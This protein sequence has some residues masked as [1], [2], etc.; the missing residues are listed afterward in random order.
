[1]QK[2]KAIFFNILR[3]ALI[4][5]TLMVLFNLF[6]FITTSNQK[7]KVSKQDSYISGTSG[8][9]Q[10]TVVNARNA[11]P[12]EA[13]V[14]VSLFEGGKWFGKKLFEGKTDVSGTL[15]A[16]FDI[17][18]IKSE[19]EHFLEIKVSSKAGW[20]KVKEKITVHNAKSKSKVT[21][22]LD[23]PLYKPGD[24][25]NF[26]A[27]ITSTHDDTPVRNQAV[28]SIFDGNENQ[29]YSKTLSSSDYGIVS[30]KFTLADQVNSG[31][32]KIKLECGKTVSE[33]L[34]EVKPFVLPK[35]KVEMDTDKNEYITGEFIKGKVRANYFFGQPVSGGKVSVKINQQ[36][37]ENLTL[38]EAGE[39]E[40]TFKV[41]G[42]GSQLISAN[43]T[44]PSNYMAEGTKTVYSGKDRIIVKMVPENKELVPGIENEVYVFTSRIDGTPL[45]TYITITGDKTTQIATDENGVAKFTVEP[46]YTSTH[47]QLVGTYN[48]KL[49]VTDENQKYTTE[50]KLSIPVSANNAGIIVRTDRPLYNINDKISLRVLSNLDAAATQLFITKSGQVL[51]VINTDS[52]NIDVELPKDTYGL[53]DIYAEKQGNFREYRGYHS[54]TT[55]ASCSKSIF[56]KP[57]NKMVLKINKENRAYKPGEDLQLA[58]EVRDD[59][60]TPLNS[61]IFLS[62]ADQ[63]LLALKD[64]DVSLD[65]LR[66]ALSDVGLDQSI[67]GLDLY[68]AILN[69]APINTL[70]ALLVGREADYP[71]LA[72]SNFDNTQ[73][74]E[75]TWSNMFK[76]LFWA[77]ILFIIFLASTYRWFRFGLLHFAG[78]LFTVFLLYMCAFFLQEADVLYIHNG[79]LFLIVVLMV[80]LYLYTTLVSSLTVYKKE[81]KVLA[82]PVAAGVTLSLLTLIG[83]I[84]VAIWISNTFTGYLN[85]GGELSSSSG[86]ELQDIGRSIQSETTGGGG[87][88]GPNMAGGID[89]K[90]SSEGEETKNMGRGLPNPFD[91]L[92]EQKV[93]QEATSDMDY[94]A[95]GNQ[96]AKPQ[97]NHR[98]KEDYAQIK[99]LRTRFLES[100]YFNPQI[101]AQ[102]GTA[103]IKIPLAD[104]ITTWNIQAVSNSMNGLIGTQNNSV[105]VFQDFF[106]DFE[107]PKN[108]TS[109]DEISIPV[110]IFN[111]LKDTQEVK[112]NVEVQDWFTLLGDNDKVFTVEPEQQKLV[113]VPI[114]INKFGNYS[115]R[116]N[117]FGKSISDGVVK[118]VK[119]Y[120]NG[121][122]VEEVCSSGKINGRAEE[123]VIFLDKDIQGTRKVRVKIYPTPMAH[124]VEGLENILRFPS[125]CFEQTSSSLYP[126]ILVLKYLKDTKKSK[127]EIEEKANQFIEVGFQ[128]LLTYEVKGERGGFS[129]Y[130]HAPAETVLTAYGLME[131]NDLKDVYPV[132]QNI[133]DRVKEYMFKKQRFD[134]SFELTGHNLGG[135]STA[136]NLALNA[137][138]GWALSE[139][140]KDDPRLKKTT[141]Y[142]KKRAFEVEDNYTLSLIANVLVN[143][144]DKEAKKVIDRLVKRITLDGE[145]NAYLTSSIRDYYGANGYMQDLQTTALASM[146]LSNSKLHPKT[147]K[148]LI[149]YII[150]KK[151]PG[152]TFGS[153]QATILAL[154]A[155]VAY[156]KSSGPRD[157]TV[158]ITVNGVEE[159]LELKASNFL[160]FY[161]KVFTNLNKENS[162][163]LTSNTELAYE[164]VKEHYIPYEQAK[165]GDGL[166]IKNVMKTYLKVN[167]QVIQRVSVASRQQQTVPNLLVTV[168]V[169]QG[170]TVDEDSLELLKTKGLIQKYEMGYDRLNFYIRDFQSY[171]V[172][173]L[174]I[175]Y[176]ARYPVS[177]TT[178]AV[179]AYDYYNPGI[180]AKLKP[181]RI[182]VE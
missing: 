143:T 12:L 158:K 95:G 97:A 5:F 62:I 182:K 173:E 71:G 70:T 108:L 125:G 171:E 36:D 52:D 165:T 135:A 157:D 50:E 13:N 44:D 74:K 160:S 96:T 156:S 163:I 87:S 112:L 25:I 177:V 170:F 40:F 178:G 54:G 176:R 7:I 137:Y 26:R 58:F 169:P 79:I 66:L 49:K 46:E 19:G 131:F 51:K 120:P 153:T 116:V 83:L 128:K 172:K 133:L 100:M 121:Y 73:K 37:S 16:S 23:K 159:Q 167:D 104:N 90:G 78:F 106:V 48:V 93:S 149:S 65:N 17:P 31:T 113:Y 82:N 88:I 35:F 117:A 30:G 33:K 118:E 94:S 2:A 162:I 139:A 152:G 102:N 11:E 147:N 1:M 166:E 32:Y 68:T 148:Q 24:E 150:A 180:E 61:A 115:F 3:G 9:C 134:G 105:K 47:P 110:T 119:V 64:N 155:L 4:I 72:E 59:K 164:I 45:K 84:S 67:N 28:V 86:R 41:K 161:E 154:K 146:A 91:G 10:I 141:E 111:Y 69:N 56:V 21:I 144:K 77:I 109:D 6:V 75:F 174:N 145:Q 85:T 38:N 175:E 60:G 22:N 151:D 81:K 123:Q 168:Q 39:G 55:K 20:D 142:L 8:G 80:A 18:E 101:I 98:S 63:A 124:V 89:I 126:D 92:F 107:M 129:L 140:C 127:P 76:W 132:D 34:F 181:V 114:K 42:E 130:G 179:H 27:L 99:K 15:N 29:V 43:V 136:E 14:K 103:S 122:K 57:D 138:I 53:I